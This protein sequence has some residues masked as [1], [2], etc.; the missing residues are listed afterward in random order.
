MTVRTD[1]GSLVPPRLADD[2]RAVALPLVVARLLT[3]LGWLLATVWAEGH[4]PG[5]TTVQLQQGL[6]AWDGSW[7][8]GIARFGYE[9]LG[10][11]VGSDEGLRFFPGYPLLGRLLSFGQESWSAA[12]LVVL[13]NAMAVVVAVAIRRTVLF[14][15][16]DEREA[17]VAVWVVCLFPSAF[18]LVWAYSEPLFL[19]GAVGG[20]LACRQRRWGWALALGALAG[21]ARPLGVLLVVPV[22]IEAVLAW[23]EAGGPGLARDRVTSGAAVLGPAIGTAGYL[24]WVGAVYG[25]PFLP[26][27]VQ[28]P[29]RGEVVDPF[30]RLARGVGDLLGPERWGDGLHLPFAVA[31]VALAVV[32]W[33]RW[34]ASYAALA[35]LLLLAALSADNLNS[36]ERYGLNAFPLLLALAMVAS[37]PWRARLVVA[38]SGAGLV[39][40]ATLAWLGTYVP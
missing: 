34:P 22:A 6:L 7:Y 8:E 5:G 29:L 16:G 4:R 24:W 13:A 14:E 28:S 33:R 26:F 20:L 11:R 3:A 10:A 19:V 27:T 31:F 36:L 2:L 12:A 18:V 38:V 21:A 37:T 23:R 15:R 35:T 40:M 32:V 17:R 25:D 30:T 39:A 9:G 1:A